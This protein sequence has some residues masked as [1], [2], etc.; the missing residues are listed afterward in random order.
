MLIL[1]DILDEI[2]LKLSN[3]FKG[4]F[5][6]TRYL[7]GILLMLLASIVS[8]TTLKEA[9]SSAPAGDNYDK[10][11]TLT[12][13]ELYTG[14]LQIGGYFNSITAEFCDT[15]G[16]NVRIIGNGAILDLQGGFITIQY[17]D[18]RL[19]ISDCVIINGGVK[20][21]GTTEGNDLLPEG[22]VSHVT[23]YQAED[24][25]VRINSCGSGILVEDNIFVDTYSTG[26]DFVNFTSFTLEWLPTG[27]NV[28]HSIF[29][30][31][32]GF[33]EINNNWSY[34]SDPRANQDSLR[35]YG[36]F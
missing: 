3:T 31:E 12:S 18:K 24:Y 17:T 29:Y 21:R 14:S 13:G 4:V 11:L 23:F 10:V 34:F 22:S 26:D 8:A 9:Y 36:M 32:Y 19:D 15:L 5:M 1:F 2:N 20:F 30:T 28:V 25:A 6:N 27:Y 7:T 33:P 35:H 16:A